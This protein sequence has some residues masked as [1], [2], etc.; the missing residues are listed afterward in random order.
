MPGQSAYAGLDLAEAVAA[1][2]DHHYE[3]RTRHIS[4]AEHEILLRAA[5][6]LRWESDPSDARRDLD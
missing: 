2:A 1:L 3:H 6:A 5:E 4:A